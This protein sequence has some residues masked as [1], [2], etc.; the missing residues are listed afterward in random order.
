MSQRQHEILTMLKDWLGEGKYLDGDFQIEARLTADE[1]GWLWD[2][3]TNLLT[4]VIKFL[5]Q[6]E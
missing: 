1:S 4:E 3:L 6:H 2:Y 5:N